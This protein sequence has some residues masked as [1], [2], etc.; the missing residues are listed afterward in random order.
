MRTSFAASSAVQTPGHSST[1]GVGRVGEWLV[2]ERD[3]WLLWMPV[4]V[5]SGIA[6]YFSL[7]REPL[8]WLGP[9]LVA[10]PAAA[11]LIGR[12]RAELAVWRPLLLCALGVA[13]GFAAAQ[14]QTTVLQ[15]RML[16]KPVGPA[17]VSGRVLRAETFP[18]GQR[19]TLDQL[20]VSRLP[21]DATP[22]RARLRLRG[23]Q[24]RIV[25]GS[26]L[27]VRAMLMP[28]PP[29]SVP[30]GF[31][32]Q[33]Q[34]FFDG[35]GAVGYSVGTAEIVVAPRSGGQDAVDGF[36]AA[37]TGIGLWFA[38]LRVLVGE[39][40][41]AH[42]EPPA[43]AVTLAL[44][45]GE[46]RA[47]AEPVMAAIRDSGLA[48]LLSISGLHI[49][50]VAGIVFLFVR[51]S[52]ALIPALALRYPIKKWAALISVL[53]AGAYTLL[54]DAPVPSQRS[55][56]MIAIVLLAV[57]VDRQGISMRL[58]AVA[59]V[60]ILLT[61]PA[62]M[63]GPSFQMSF[64]AVVALI[65][66][67]EVLRERRRAPAE[68][69]SPAGRLAIY[70]AGVVLSTLIAGNATAPFAAYH[71]N[72]FQLYSVAANM[73]AVP[74]TGFWIMPWA[75]LAL[76]LMPLGLEGPALIAMSWGVDVVIWIARTVASWPGA[77]L[78]L[79]PMPTWG[80]ALITMGG[81]WLCLWQQR[82]RLLGAVPIAAGVAAMLTVQVPDV[83]IDGA[84]KLVAVRDENGG[85]ILSSKIA[86]R[87]A[88]ESWL[89]RAGE[90]AAA[91]YWPKPGAPGGDVLRCDS[92]G[93]VYR[94]GAGIARID[95]QVGENAQGGEAAT[96]DD[97]TRKRGHVVAIARRGEAL[98]D[99][100]RRA[101]VVVS[102][103]PVRA[104][105]PSA[106]V[107]ID[108]FDLWRDGAHALWLRPDSVR[109]ASVNGQRGDRPWVLRPPAGGSDIRLSHG[110][111][112][113]AV[114]CARPVVVDAAPV[115]A[116]A[117]DAQTLAAGMG[118]RSEREGRGADDKAC[119]R[120]MRPE[121]PAE[122]PEPGSFVGPDK[123]T[124]SPVESEDDDPDNPIGDDT[125]CG[126]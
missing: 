41:R 28:P 8:P 99:D 12:F 46:Q 18:D 62:S 7:G 91:G 58:V 121:V 94:T 80:L 17:L 124:R 61:Q 120:A 60:V 114:T 27:S 75:V 126:C 90:E 68:Q 108:R 109:V 111:Q 38:R 119:G 103:I 81:L 63:L 19:I 71:F 74:V 43:D 55:F 104:R 25:P 89:R 66:A 22:E 26:R 52:L 116:G 33:R 113:S 42:V 76:L 82:W 79:P 118:G 44:L 117:L 93:C 105:C 84:G 24:P 45:T 112:G 37:G 85:L 11:M 69:P 70:L 77:V 125:G 106:A 20:S 2:A 92:L 101:D 40:V 65:A 98:S 97:G 49:G 53:A 57:L 14:L 9:L 34:A 39:Q 23:E 64:A 123:P 16:A 107:V 59:A 1:E 96:T 122:A 6:V 31:D 100:C 78:L 56:L 48:H 47:I 67:Y 88:R 83:L 3:R 10:L 87:A 102:L 13:V 51:G 32:F 4:L 115:D 72:R 21:A 54:A 50:L 86:G 36:F 5:G 30:G 73:V 35:L 95:G 29:P 110:L 15:T